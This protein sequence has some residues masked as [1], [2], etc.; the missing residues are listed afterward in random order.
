MT[1]KTV[2]I[3]VLLTAL[4]W[5]ASV[6]AQ[7]KP[8]VKNNKAA[9]AEVLRDTASKKKAVKPLVFVGQSDFAGGTIAP[10]DF[11]ALIRQG[12]T[13]KDATTG[14]LLRVIGFNFMYAER[15]LYENEKGDMS[16]QT[17]FSTIYTNGSMLDTGI[18]SG[19]AETLK[20]GDT[21]FI[22]QVMVERKSGSKTD[23]ILGKEVTCA[24]KR[25]Q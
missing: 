14:A 17:E 2:K 7:K 25:K 4:V 6:W 16:M 11:L 15:R 10:L 20:S 5:C 24:M 13:A 18:I 9:A 19:L 8:P 21:I 12:L 23:T 1:S 3:V 22:N